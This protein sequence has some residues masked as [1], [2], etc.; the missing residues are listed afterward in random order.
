MSWLIC[1]F[2][3]AV[4]L[5]QLTLVKFNHVL[6]P[7]A[8]LAV[9]AAA[10]APIAYIPYGVSGA[11]CDENFIFYCQVGCKCPVFGIVVNIF[12]FAVFL[13]YLCSFH[14]GKVI[15]NSLIK[16]EKNKLFSNLE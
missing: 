9:V 11:G 13:I 15:N 10:C 2:N 16:Q 4:E 14:G 6:C 7:I 3:F 12:D 1:R 8:Y 5:A